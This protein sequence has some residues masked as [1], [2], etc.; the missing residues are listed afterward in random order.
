MKYSDIKVQ[1]IYNVIFDEVR[2]NE[3][4]GT[5]LALVLKKNN[6]IR[7]A[8]VMP[9][10]S[11]SNGEGKN[12]IKIDVLSLPPSLA[13]NQTYAVYNQIRTLNASRFMNLKN[14]ARNPIDVNVS[15]ETYLNL[16]NLGIKDLVFNIGDNERI[17]LFRT[18][19]FNEK[20]IKSKGLAY[21]VRNQNLDE[22]QLQKINEEIY[23][24]VNDIKIEFTNIE[25]NHGIDKI[26]G[27]ILN[28]NS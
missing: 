25:I 10:T 13:S 12:K 18:I 5:H 17:E 20:V 15:I 2:D 16:L 9:L 3:F 22:S 19:Y 4:N 8:V 27:H 21:N 26:I 11:I 14:D 24:L 6:D 1:H 23:T 28:K 7:T